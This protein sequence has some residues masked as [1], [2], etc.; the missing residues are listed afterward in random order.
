[1]KFL[2][3]GFFLLIS[4]LH[5]QA[6]VSVRI[7]PDTQNLEFLENSEIKYKLQCG[8]V[9]ELARFENQ[10]F[11]ASYG[12]DLKD[13]KIIIIYG[14]ADKPGSMEF[15]AFGQK[16]CLSDVAAITIRVSKESVVYTAG[17]VGKVTIGS[18]SLAAGESIS[19]PNS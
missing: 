5:T 6:A 19:K 2:S 14:D 15:E 3:V 1:M 13:Q 4:L 8:S 7:D 17:L 9:R 16:I 12:K 11:R 18:A 10:S